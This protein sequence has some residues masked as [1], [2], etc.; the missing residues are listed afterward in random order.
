MTPKE[1]FINLIKYVPNVINTDYAILVRKTKIHFGEK[2]IGLEHFSHLM[3]ILIALD[4]DTP[5]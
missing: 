3:Y 1:S 2:Y 4:Y 5:K